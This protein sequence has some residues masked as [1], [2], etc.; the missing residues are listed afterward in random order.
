GSLAE[1]NAVTDEIVGQGYRLSRLHIAPLSHPWTAP[2]PPG[3]FR[4]GCAPLEALDAARRLLAAA[5]ADAVVVQGRDLLRS[6]YARDR[7]L[8]SRR[9]AVYG[10]QQPLTEAYTELARAFCRRVGLDAGGFRDLAERLFENHVRVWEAAGHPIQPRP[11]WF[12]PVTE[13]FRRVDCANPVVDFEGAAVVT[14]TAVAEAC[15]VPAHQRIPVLGVALAWAS[16]DGP[17]YV[18]EIAEYRHLTTAYREACLQAAVEFGPRYLAGAALLEAYTCYP[19]V[20]LAFLLA[21]GIARDP[22]ELPDLLARH[23][24]TVTGGMNLARAA[25]NNPALHGLATLWERLSKGAAPL[26]ALH[27]NGGLGQRQGVAILG[28]PTTA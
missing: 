11:E 21:S 3:H 28:G 6:E 20:P 12:A 25:W 10:E 8:R 23:P 13:L 5:N 15:G 4:S 7:A 17:E 27:A 2:L 26:A 18:E 9:M 14:T 16:G 24:V 22:G 1:V 19:V